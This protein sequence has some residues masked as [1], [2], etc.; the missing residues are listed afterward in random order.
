MR[1]TTIAQHARS[2]HAEV[3]VEGRI[4]TVIASRVISWV[5]L[6]PDLSVGW[7]CSLDTIHY[8]VL[9]PHPLKA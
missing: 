9:P 8:L 2:T 1:E 5:I 4:T 6:V 7:R 3:K